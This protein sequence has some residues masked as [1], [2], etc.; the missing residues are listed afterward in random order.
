MKQTLR[1]KIRGL[2]NIRKMK[3]LGVLL[4]VLSW[5]SPR[6]CIKHDLKKNKIVMASTTGF[7]RH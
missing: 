4:V 1:G 7:F 2:Q 5:R 3:M 6:T